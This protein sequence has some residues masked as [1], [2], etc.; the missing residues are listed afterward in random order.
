MRKV[1]LLLALVLFGYGEEVI[2]KLKE[3]IGQDLGK[4]VLFVRYGQGAFDW[5]AVTSD[6]KFMAKLEGVEEDGTFKY[7]ILGDPKKYGL[8]FEISLEGVKLKKALDEPA[9]TK[10]MLKAL[11]KSLIIKALPTTRSLPLIVN[12]KKG[13]DMEVKIDKDKT[14]ILYR[15]C[16]YNEDVILDGTQ[17]IEEVIT[18]KDFTITTS[19]ATIKIPTATLRVGLNSYHL[20]SPYL[21]IYD[22]SNALT[23]L[24]EYVL[25][26]TLYSDYTQ[27]VT[28]GLIKT[29]C[30]QEWANLETLEPILVRKDEKCPYSG[31]LKATNSKSEVIINFKEEG[32]EIEGELYSCQDLSQEAV[33]R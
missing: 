25:D 12:C 32:I 6:G 8:R 21:E 15:S 18:Y 28:N 4:P 17:E 11:G 26:L 19:S 33:C 14:I 16:V 23:Q 1:V 9:L 5:L 3:K 20:T 31:S 24:K 29:E 7:K 22:Q 13:G 30:T 27:I 10:A 2:E